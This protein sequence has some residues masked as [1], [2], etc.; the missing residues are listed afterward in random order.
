M[1]LGNAQLSMRTRAMSAKFDGILVVLSIVIIGL[2]AHGA[3]LGKLGLYRDDAWQFMQGMQAADGNT[4]NFVLSDTSGSLLTE[5]PFSYVP[6]TIARVAFAISLPVAHWI[7]VAV[8]ILNALIL[9]RITHEIYS[10]KWFVFSVGVI[11]ITYPLSPMQMITLSTIHYLFSSL[12]TFLAILFSLNG[13]KRIGSR[14]LYW[15]AIGS[16]T[17]LASLLTHEEFGPIYPLFIILYILSSYKRQ[18]I[19]YH[20]PKDIRTVSP[21]ILWLISFLL[22]LGLYGLW[23][24]VILPLYKANY[25]VD[26]YNLELDPATLVKKFIVGADTVFAPWDQI[27][28]QIFRFQPPLWSVLSSGIVFAA[29]WIVIFRLL[30]H[31]QVTSHV[32]GGSLKIEDGP[33]CQVVITG[34]VLVIAVIGT[35]AP[36]STNAV[37]TV[38]NFASRVNFGALAGIALGL[39]AAPVLLMKF[40]NRSVRATIFVATVF[41]AF[42]GIIH[43]VVR[44]SYITAILDRYP[45]NVG[46]MVMATTLGVIFIIF[47]IILSSYNQTIQ[48]RTI[49]LIGRSLK[50]GYALIRVHVL[51]VIIASIVLQGSLF[52]SSMKYEWADAWRQY[53]LMLRGLQAVAPGFLDETVVLIIEKASNVLTTRV[54]KG[55]EL[56]IHLLGLYNNWSIMGLIITKGAS[57]WYFYRDGMEIPGA[58]WFPAGVRGPFLTHATMSI[59]RIGYNRFVLCEFDGSTLRRVPKIEVE[60]VEGDLLIL[61]D[62]PERVLAGAPVA[63]T[64]WRHVTQ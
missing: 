39:P 22:T 51:A 54:V 38:H 21:V 19:K 9:A 42:F 30:A 37:E 11:F 1:G 60:T 15:F 36:S 7:L 45:L 43:I 14:Q 26:F 18:G 59:P 4:L 64:I 8:L 27:F 12:L 31:S 55:S 46:M 49:H 3:S 57:G 5:R 10:E 48:S 61:H 56:S 16:S 23:R 63:N 53:K 34:T 41:L 24:K 6:W 13:L 52:H 17:Y 25:F 29:T 28:W 50:P 2:L 62:N 35:V 20:P 58:T 47:M 40:C 44:R 33:W 32:S